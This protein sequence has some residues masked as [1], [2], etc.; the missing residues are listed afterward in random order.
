MTTFVSRRLPQFALVA[1]AALGLLFGAARTA[2]AFTYGPAN[3]VT[4]DGS[5]NLQDPDRQF[6][7][8]GNSSSADS[9][10]QATVQMG[11]GLSLQFGA[12]NSR[13]SF[14]AEYNSHV[15]RMFNPSDS[16]GGN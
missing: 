5:A 6:E 16:P 1:V 14:D 2:Q 13:S 8:S 11:G 15:N 4:P 10:G 12:R 9:H 7:S 3:S